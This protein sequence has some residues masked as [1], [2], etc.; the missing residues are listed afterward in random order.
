MISK[1]NLYLLFG[2]CAAVF[3]AFFLLPLSRLFLESLDGPEKIRL[4]SQIIHNPRYFKS[5]ADTL[6]I[7]IA[8]SASA[9]FI[10]SAAGLFLARNRFRG[11]A[12]LVSLITLP[13]SFPGV[14][15]GFMVIMLA[16]RQGLIGAASKALFGEKIVFAY[17]A[18]GLFMG[19]L[20]FSI[21]R[22]AAAVMASAEK[23]DISLEEAARVSGAGPFRVLKDV[24]I[25]GLMPALVSSGAVCFATS[26]GAFGTAFTLAT[27]INV[28]PIIIYT[29]FTLSANIASA[30]MLSLTLGLVTFLALSLARLISESALTGGAA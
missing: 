29:E 11:R 19:Y 22:V 21:P 14:A 25:P 30:S 27:D 15:V 13:I 2:P 3:A 16:G 9:A 5:L 4:Y 17:S 18:L 7:S 8:V 26:V 12:L 23:L 24:T 20:Y 10:G 1:K 6:I 28:L